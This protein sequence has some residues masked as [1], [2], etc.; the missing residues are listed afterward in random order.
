MKVY[1][2]KLSGIIGEVRGSAD[3]LSSASEAKV[4]ATAQSLSPGSP[5]NR[6]RGWRDQR[7]VEQDERFDQPDTP[8]HAKV[9]DG[10]RA[11]H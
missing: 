3:A 6:R 9:I 10:Q 5:A 1:G 7:S 8:R 11:R 4:S 2:G